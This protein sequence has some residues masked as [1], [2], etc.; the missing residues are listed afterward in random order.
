MNQ[1]RNEIE[2]RQRR[3]GARTTSRTARLR[4]PI[5]LF[6]EDGGVCAFRTV[7]HAMKHGDLDGHF[8]DAGGRPLRRVDGSSKRLMVE[9]EEDRRAYVREQV[10]QRL[11]R[12]LRDTEPNQDTKQALDDIRRF[13]DEVD[14]EPGLSFPKFASRLALLLR[15]EAVDPTYSTGTWAHYLCAAHH[16]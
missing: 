11:K 5:I 9:S 13:L 1:P 7:G 16:R 10:R 12:V 14:G 4:S 2:D 15:P 3:E 8:F 6:E